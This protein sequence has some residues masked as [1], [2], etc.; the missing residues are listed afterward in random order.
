M[1]R[2]EQPKTARGTDLGFWP[3]ACRGIGG[4]GQPEVADG[5]LYGPAAAAHCIDPKR[6]DLCELPQPHALFALQHGLHMAQREGLDAQDVGQ[7]SAQHSC[8]SGCCPVHK[9][10]EHLAALDAAGPEALELLLGCWEGNTD[11]RSVVAGCSTRQAVSL[12]CGSCRNTAATDGAMPGIMPWTMGKTPETHKHT[13]RLLHS[14]THAVVSS[15][16]LSAEHADMDPDCDLQY[17]VQG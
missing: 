13:Q 17:L 7:L 15:P 2:Y 14:T 8:A 16:S 4:L 9:L 1:I 6:E 5:D 11:T 3:A 10:V 12:H